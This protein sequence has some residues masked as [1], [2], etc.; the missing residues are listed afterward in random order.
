M[1]PSGSI[2][3]GRK[4]RLVQDLRF[5]HGQ[6]FLLSVLPVSFSCPHFLAGLPVPCLCIADSDSVLLSLF[7]VLRTHGWRF[8]CQ[9]LDCKQPQAPAVV[10]ALLD[11]G[12][13]GLGGAVPH[14]RGQ[15]KV[16]SCSCWHLLS[17]QACTLW[18]APNSDTALLAELFVCAICLSRPR[19]KTEELFQMG[20]LW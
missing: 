15:K 12:L 1:S 11:L 16:W 5:D 7:S 14:G 2:C 18:L 3:L 8:T 19:Q 13:L 10:P 6:F 4:V 17:Q 20:S 9:L